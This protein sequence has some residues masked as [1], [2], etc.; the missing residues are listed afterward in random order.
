MHDKTIISRTSENVV[1]YIQRNATLEAQK[2]MAIA[3]VTTAITK[4]GCSILQALD[5]YRFSSKT[6]RQYVGL[7]FVIA[8]C[9]S[10]PDN[11]TDE[12]IAEQFSS[13]RGYHDIYPHWQFA[14]QQRL[15]TDSTGIC[16][17]TCLQKGTSESQV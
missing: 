9:T 16:T 5:C 7:F 3:I 6:V 8:T 12:F 13:N 4:R 17:Y 11:M 10:S 1:Q 15:L 14:S 2:A